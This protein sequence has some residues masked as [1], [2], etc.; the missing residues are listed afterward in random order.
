MSSSDA[1]M[2]WRA[3]SKQF[4]RWAVGT[5]GVTAQCRQAQELLSLGLAHRD[6][7]NQITGSLGPSPVAGS[8]DLG[9]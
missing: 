7:E 9:L 1:L 5:D 2:A 8:T 6:P 4:D 3:Q